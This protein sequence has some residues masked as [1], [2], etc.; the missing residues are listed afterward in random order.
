MITHSSAHE[1]EVL[2]S[3]RQHMTG[4][5]YHLGPGRGVLALKVW[6]SKGHACPEVG[7]T[8]T[9]RCCG[10]GCCGDGG[11]CWFWSRTVAAATRAWS[12]PLLRLNSPGRW[13][14]AS[15]ALTGTHDGVLL[16]VNPRG[17]LEPSSLPAH[18]LSRF[19]WILKWV[20]DTAHNLRAIRMALQ[21]EHGGG[22]FECT[23]GRWTDSHLCRRCRWRQR[24]RWRCRSASRCRWRPRLTRC[25]PCCCPCRSAA[26]PSCRCCRRRCCRRPRRSTRSRPGLHA[27]TR[28]KLTTQ[29]S[30]ILN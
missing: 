8:G 16:R 13:A 28:T 10:A 24:G 14:G 3:T 25:C 6:P 22:T 17:L 30:F 4:Q 7:T 1:L 2:C 20:D 18:H 9:G 27:H 21:V 26:G 29:H 11:C 19:R 5:S 12:M 23:G 15:P